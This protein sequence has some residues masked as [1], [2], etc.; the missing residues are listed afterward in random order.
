MILAHNKKQFT[1]VVEA[2]V[3]LNLLLLSNEVSA[4]DE[5]YEEWVML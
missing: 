2:P 5:Q 3:N 1:S 4:D